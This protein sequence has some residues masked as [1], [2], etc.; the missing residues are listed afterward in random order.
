[1]A[2]HEKRRLPGLAV[3]WSPDS[4]Y[5]TLLLGE[6]F[7]RL[8]IYDV[9]KE[10]VVWEGDFIFPATDAPP[11]STVQGTWSPDGSRFLYLGQGQLAEQPRQ[12]VTRVVE[13]ATGRVETMSDVTWPIDISP[14]GQYIAYSTGGE[15]PRGG[16]LWVVGMDGTGRAQLAGGA[17]PKWRVVPGP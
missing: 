2:T 15:L 13:V 9:G 7:D 5:L 16:E 8:V 3:S 17:Y 14:G 4:R 11:A 1:V 10:E 12:N 6:E